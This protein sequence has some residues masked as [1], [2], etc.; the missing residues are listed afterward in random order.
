MKKQ[1]EKTEK[2]IQIINE[3]NTLNDSLFVKEAELQSE[4]QE[5]FDKQAGLTQGKSFVL[6]DGKEYV[7]MGLETNSYCP[8]GFINDTNIY[9]RKI[10]KSGK[11]SKN[12]RLL[13]WKWKKMNKEYKAL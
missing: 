8:Y 3:I 9:V 12:K 10:T 6:C 7:Y 5:E 1:F 2:I 4:I 13:C 11:L